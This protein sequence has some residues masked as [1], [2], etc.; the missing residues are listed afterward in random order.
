MLLLDYSQKAAIG[1]H[2]LLEQKHK[3]RL[4]VKCVQGMKTTMNLRAKKIELVQLILNTDKPSVLAKVEAVFKKEK[5]TDWWNEISEA[6]R[7]A[8][9]ESLDEADRGKLIPHE[10]VMKEVRAKYNLD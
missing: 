1:K 7:T 10:E 4:I 9:E 3:W 2:H 5:D 8:I 6:E